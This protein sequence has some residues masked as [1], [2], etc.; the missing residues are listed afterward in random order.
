MAQKYRIFFG[1]H[2]FLLGGHTNRADLEINRLKPDIIYGTLEMLRTLSNPLTIKLHEDIHF[3]QF[4]EL[5]KYIVAAGGAVFNPKDELL[6]I[7]RFGYWDLPKGKL[8]KR[9][10]L[11]EG[12]IREVEEECNVFGLTIEEE[13]TPTFHIFHKKR[14]S[15]KK[16]YWYRMHCEIWEKAKPQ[17]EEGIDRIAWKKLDLINPSEL[18]TYPAIRSLLHQLVLQEE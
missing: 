2:L 1:E 12:A 4:R 11:Q 9:E 3:D 10:S 6:L 5:F 7:H 17:K 15:L 16:S 13:L 14:W 18:H 8:E